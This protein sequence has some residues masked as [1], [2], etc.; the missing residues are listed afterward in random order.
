MSAKPQQ[1]IAQLETTV[2]VLQLMS[3]AVPDARILN[4][5]TKHDGSLIHLWEDDFDAF[6]QKHELTDISVETRPH[7]MMHCSVILKLGESNIEVFTLRELDL[8]VLKRS[9]D[10][11]NE[12]QPVSK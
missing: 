9:M 8:E 11:Q 7:N 3:E 2:Y 5:Y 1:V 4:V 12:E 10:A 6:C